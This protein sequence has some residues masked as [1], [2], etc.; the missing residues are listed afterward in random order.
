MKKHERIK[1]D[2][3]IMFGKPVITGTRI[4][5][6]LILRKLAAGMTPEE[7]LKAHPHLTMKFLADECCDAEI[8]S[9]LRSEGHDVA[10]IPEI[11]PG[12]RIAKYFH[13]LPKEKDYFSPK[14]K[15]LASS[16]FG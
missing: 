1:I 10:Y 4:T 11:K 12:P 14:T 2:P 6:E 16:Y 13:W 5:V 15:I 7:I 3:E 8:V 9:L